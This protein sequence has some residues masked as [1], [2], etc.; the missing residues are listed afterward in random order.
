MGSFQLSGF[1][2]QKKLALTFGSCVSFFAKKKKFFSDKTRDVKESMPSEQ[3]LKESK[4]LSLSFLRFQFSLFLENTNLKAY[5]LQRHTQK[6][7]HE[8]ETKKER[9]LLYLLC[10]HNNI[11]K[12]L[13]IKPFLCLLKL[14]VSQISLD[15][16]SVGLAFFTCEKH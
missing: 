13:L 14:F 1:L 11:S 3:G 2:R 15:I 4:T 16:S 6:K 12:F 9:R 8:K 5:K 10:V 7:M